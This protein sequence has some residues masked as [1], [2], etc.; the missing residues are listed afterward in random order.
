MFDDVFRPDTESGNLEHR[1]T[2]ALESIAVSLSIIVNKLGGSDE[3]NLN[4][5]L[6]TDKPIKVKE[7]NNE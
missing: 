2:K 3:N 1:Q 6:F 7:V 4:V 5:T